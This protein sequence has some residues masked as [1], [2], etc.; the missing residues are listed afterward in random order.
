MALADRVAICSE[1]LVLIGDAP[2]TSM[3]DTTAGARAARL[4]YDRAVRARLSWPYGWSRKVGGPLA[5]VAG[6]APAGS[7]YSARFTLP[8]DHLLTIVPRIGDAE[9]LASEGWETVDGY[10]CLDADADE[11]VTL[12]YH[13]MVDEGRWSA[14]FRQGIVFDLAAQF[15]TSVRESAELANFY[16]PQAEAEFLRARAASAQQQ[17]ATGLPLGRF[18]RLRRT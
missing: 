2:I 9:L 17:P 15:A 7:R 8:S 12:Y 1:A 4:A 14:L 6:A 13:G 11:A 5:R 18:A 3:E 10:L 16:R